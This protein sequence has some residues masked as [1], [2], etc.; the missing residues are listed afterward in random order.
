[1][2]L[3]ADQIATA[4]AV[5]KDVLDPIKSQGARLTLSPVLQGPMSKGEFQVFYAGSTNTPPNRET[6]NSGLKQARTLRFI[7]NLLLKD[8]RDPEAAVP[9]LEQA[10]TLL[11]GL[12]LFG[13]QPYNTYDGA[14]YPATDSFR[15]RNDEAFY[16]YSLE[17]RCEVQDYLPA[18]YLPTPD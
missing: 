11:T 4:Q 8:L 1:M 10:K 13:E 14:L 6:F 7:C 16:F 18:P 2:A 5:L 3:T 17:M 12:Q 9:I 15:Q